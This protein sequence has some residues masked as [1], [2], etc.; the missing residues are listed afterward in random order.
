M[1]HFALLLT[2][3]TTTTLSGQRYE[4][5]YLNSSDSSFNCYLKVIPESGSIRGL[6]IRDYSSVPDTA[7]KSPYKIEALCT[8]QGLMTLYTVSSN[9]FPEFFCSDS[10]ISRLD[11]MVG[12]VIA[13]HAIPK[14]NIFIGGI[15]ASGTR[16]LRYAQY[17]RQGKSKF[18]IKIRGVFAVDPP[19]DLARFYCSVDRHK[20]NFKAGMLWEADLMVKVW[21]H[22]F[23]GSPDEFPKEYLDASVFSHQDSLGGN[24]VFLKECDIILYHEPDIDWWL[25]ERGASYYDINSFDI[26]AFAL[27]LKILGNKNVKLVTTT[28]KGFDRD[29]SRKCHSWTIVDEEELVNWIT[30][31]MEGK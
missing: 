2:F 25:E 11:E 17:C 16:A 1:K 19:F 6:V 24:A 14:E 18:G 7:K 10:V 26:A 21:P 28:G 20:A 12:E 4:Y 5:V 31:R 30:E 29:G 27:K 9:F 22:Y 3:L 23:S 15:S 13:E 8:E